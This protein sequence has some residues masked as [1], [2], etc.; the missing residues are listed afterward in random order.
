M[1]DENTVR[2][3][4]HRQNINR[5]R[6]LLKTPLTTLEREFLDRRI[7]E[8]EAEIHRLIAESNW[9]TALGTSS[10]EWQAGGAGRLGPQ[11]TSGC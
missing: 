5:Y 4:V 6:S 10:A 1:P 7:G 11:P 2:F 9:H 8:E 3:L